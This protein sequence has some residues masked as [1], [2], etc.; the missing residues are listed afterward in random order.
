MKF[1]SPLRYPGSKRKLVNFFK[2]IVIKNGLQGCVYVE[3][4]AGGA[5]IALS[6]LIEGYFSR[7]IINDLDRS[8]YA[9]WYS[10][11][12]NTKKF[13]KLIEETPVNIETWNK[14]K[15]IQKGK[16][17][18][19][20]LS[21]GFS[22]FFLNRTNRS[23][24]LNAGVIGGIKQKGNWKINARYNKKDLIKRIKEIAKHKKEIE[25]YNEDAIEL[26]KKLKNKLTSNTLIYFDPPYFIKG[27][28]LY[29]NH[30][31]YE[32]H[33]KIAKEIF[34]IK[35]QKWVITYDD[36]EPIIKLYRKH[37]LQ[38]Y[39][40]RYSAGNSRIGREIMAHSNNIIMPR[41]H[42]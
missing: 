11:L 18:V 1:Y 5:S 14:Q 10:I 39:L 20:L 31:E 17:T 19:D 29:F 42:S 2:E 3:P 4:Y 38:T 23:G 40:L 15:E 26:I 35:S 27:K 9:F 24:I 33:K 6:L 25:V 30:Y 41:I 7:I 28:E 8:I 22:T 13:C 36:E 37:D 12:N 21:L 16:E 32:D 34:R